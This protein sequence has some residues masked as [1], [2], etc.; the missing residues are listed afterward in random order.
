MVKHNNIIPNQHFHKKWAR[1][2]K[3]WFQQPIQKKI[4]REKRKVK[5]A[6]IAPRPASGPLKP[7]V[8]C[9]TQK[10]NSKVKLGRGFTLEELKEAGIN[11]TF[12]QTI[13][14]SV[15][16]RRTNKSEESLKVNVA[17]LKEYKERLV[18]FPRHLKKVKGG[19]SDKS[20]TSDAQQLV[21]E[22]VAAPAAER[23]ISHITITDEMKAAK[24]YGAI[25]A[26]RNDKRLAGRRMKK[27]AEKKAEAEK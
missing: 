15:D 17:R 11:R 14:I 13:G 3:T 12:A 27:A 5:A 18:I 25:R 26:A 4:R 22:L 6:A 1:R 8:H 7:L 2:V 21:G 16:H 24:G 19:D 10:Y 23:A 9:P 20:A